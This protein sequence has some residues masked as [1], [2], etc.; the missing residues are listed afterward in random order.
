MILWSKTEVLP[1]NC[2][3]P[4]TS[5]LYFER[6]RLPSPGCLSWGNQQN[7]TYLEVLEWNS[8]SREGIDSLVKKQL[9]MTAAWHIPER[10]LVSRRGLKC[11]QVQLEMPI[12]EAVQE[13]TATP[14]TVWE[15]SYEWKQ[16]ALEKQAETSLTLANEG[17]KI[18]VIRTANQINEIDLLRRTGS[19]KLQENIALQLV[20]RHHLSSTGAPSSDKK[21]EGFC[22]PG[23]VC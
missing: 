9:F 16:N 2:D 11:V 19:P 1:Y 6:Q 12:V 4:D 13:V 22:R 10:D 5:T 7:T 3:S 8:R 17:H 15:K 21:Q 20:M 14:P 18:G 23:A